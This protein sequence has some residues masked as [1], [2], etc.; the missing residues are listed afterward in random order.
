MGDFGS[1]AIEKHL[2]EVETYLDRGERW[3]AAFEMRNCRVITASERK[4][5]TDLITRRGP[6]F[7][8]TIQRC[9]LVTESSLHRGAL[10]AITWVVPLPFDVK[11][12]SDS[13]GAERWLRET[14]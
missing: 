7:K 13:A 6:H 9:A 1:N 2:A 8:Q 14:L 3:A 11:F 4:Q 5:Y 10:T 12:F